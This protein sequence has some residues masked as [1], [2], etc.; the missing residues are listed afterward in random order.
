MAKII[1]FHEIKNPKWFEETLTILKKIYPKGTLQDVENFYKGDRKNFF[2]ITVDDG[3]LSNYHT[4]YPCIKKLDLTASIFVSPYITKTGKNFWFQEIEGYNQD[5]LREI[6]AQKFNLNK[7]DLQKFFVSSMLKNM[8][9]DDIEEIINIYKTKHNPAP[10]PR[11]NMNISELKEL[12]HSGLFDI[13]A[14]TMRHPILANETDA[15]VKKQI[16]DSISELSDILNTEIR[17]FAYPNGDSS[18]DFGNRE[19]NILKNTS[20]KYAYT[21]DYRKLRST[22]DLYLIPRFGLNRGTSSYIKNRMIMGEFWEKIKTTLFNTETKHRNEIKKH[23][24]FLT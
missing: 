18:I 19:T 7:K 9:I 3:D 6:I 5:Y 8:R 24:D 14:H 15:D 16:E 2:H 4:I 12:H 17:H 1:N 23:F 10:K 13:G 22:D 21:F 11:K 20:I